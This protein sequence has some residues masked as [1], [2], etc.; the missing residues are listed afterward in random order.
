[1]GMFFS[2]A[3]NCSFA[4]GEKKAQ[5]VLSVCDTVM[6]NRTEDLVFPFHVIAPASEMLYA[7]VPF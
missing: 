6:E 2:S 5:F 7:V 1:M 4:S 3:I